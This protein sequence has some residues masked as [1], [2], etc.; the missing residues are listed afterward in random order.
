[1][2]KHDCRAPSLFPWLQRRM[3]CDGVLCGAVPAPYAGRIAEDIDDEGEAEGG[4]GG[5]DDP[6]T[7]RIYGPIGDGFFWRGHT[8]ETLQAS[9]DAAG[10]QDVTLRIH[11]P[12]GSAFEGMAMHTALRD[13]EGHVTARVDGVAASAALILMLGAD[14]ATAPP[15]A[16]LM[17]HEA[18]LL[19]IGNEHGLRDDL[20]LL[21]GLDSQQ[22]EML[23]RKTGET[24]AYWQGHLANHDRWYTAREAAEA[25]LLDAI[26]EP[27]GEPAKGSGGQGDGGDG[28]GDATAKARARGRIA[29]AR[30]RA[31]MRA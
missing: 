20:A 7:I 6:T 19:T 12:G 26:D 8:L 17:A 4:G 28:G 11:S 23:A 1:M 29:V 9:L 3:P 24:Q 18:W 2:A 25:G 13:Y 5:A 22:V 31:R 16:T 27:A 30:A 15:T 21:E 10:G 14:E